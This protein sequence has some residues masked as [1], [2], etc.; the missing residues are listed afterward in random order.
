MFYIT[1]KVLVVK[2]GQKVAVE[3]KSYSGYDPEQR[4][5]IMC[6]HE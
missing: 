5:F 3:A 4:A 6:E 1:Y 2:G